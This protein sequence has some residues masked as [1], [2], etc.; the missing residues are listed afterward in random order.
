MVTREELMERLKL[1]EN[2]IRKMTVLNNNLKQCNEEMEEIQKKIKQDKDMT[3]GVYIGITIFTTALAGVAAF[4]ISR[5]IVRILKVVFPISVS[6]QDK[7]ILIV[8]GIA[9]LIALLF[10][11]ALILDARDAPKRIAKW[12]EELA[13]KKQ[14]QVSLKNELKE[15]KGSVEWSKAV[16]YIPKDYFYLSAIEKIRSFVKNGRADT[17]KEALDLY[18]E[19]LHREKMEYEARRAADEAERAADNAEMTAIA[20]QEA[21]EYAK[22][23]AEKAQSMEYLAQMNAYRTTTVQNNVDIDITFE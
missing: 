1:S 4:F 21:T 9:C 2:A 3:V 18:E 23:T 11:I 20:A 7:I 10:G 19:F 22:I 12:E 8:T 16:S 5:L 14:K 13:D 15:Y 6:V 17:M